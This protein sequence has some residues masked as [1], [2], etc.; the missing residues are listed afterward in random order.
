MAIITTLRVRLKPLKTVSWGHNDP[1]PKK[2]DSRGSCW[3]IVADIVFI[4]SGL[5]MAT[6]SRG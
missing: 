5:E 2:L 1:L 3:F 4:L 6:I